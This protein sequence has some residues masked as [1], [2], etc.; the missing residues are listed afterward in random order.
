MYMDRTIFSV[1][2]QEHEIKQSL[3]PPLSFCTELVI[4]MNDS[5][6]PS[7]YLLEYWVC[8]FGEVS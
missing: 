3:K 5:L 7:H 4:I 2:R 6:S 1:C 8:Q